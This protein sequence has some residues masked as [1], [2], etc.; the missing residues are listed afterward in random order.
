MKTLTVLGNSVSIRLRPKDEEGKIYSDILNLQP[1]LSVTNLGKGASMIVDQDFSGIQS[2]LALLNYGIVEASTRPIS[3][4]LYKTLYLSEETPFWFKPISFCLKYLES[5]FRSQLVN[6]RGNKSWL[7]P[8]EFKLQLENALHV[9]KRN[10]VRVILIGINKPSNRIEKQLPQTIDNVLIYNSILE[11][12]A[13]DFKVD[14]VKT[15]EEYTPD[16][17]PD[18][19]HFSTAGHQKLAKELLDLI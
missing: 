9:L 12:V 19:I 4:K 13:T 1:D 17:M 5:K 15:F 7:S 8:E 2:D 18:G 14:F 6:L 3:R 11:Q 16:L 10:K